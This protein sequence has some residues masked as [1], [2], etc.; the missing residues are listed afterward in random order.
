MNLCSNRQP[1]PTSR[2]AMLQQ[3]GTG[4]GALALNAMLTG[5]GLAASKPAPTTARAK[6]VIF[7]FMHGGPS[8]VDL[9]DPKPLLKRD[10]GK[11]LPFKEPRIVSHK[12]GN[13]LP[14]P[15]QFSRHGQ[16]GAPVSEL[17]PHIGSI[18]DDLCFI[19]SMHCSNSRH[20]GAL[21]ELHTGSDTFT[22]PAM[23][24]WIN[25]G[26]G[27]ENENLPGFITIN[28]SGS[29]GGAGAWSPAFLPARHGGT[30]ISGSGAEMKIPFIES[31]ISK[32]KRQL[33][34]IDLIKAFNRDHLATHGTDSEL[35]SRIASYELAFRM[36][37]EVPGIQDLSNEPAHIKKMYGADEAPTKGFAEQCMMA[38]RFSEAGV[39]FVQI[40]HRYWDSHSNLRKE[41]KKLSAEM[42]K[43]V[44]ALITDL[45]QRG[46]LEDTLVL[47]GS[48]F[49]RTPTA[50]GND[51]RDHNPHGFTMFMA[52]GG[53]RP[54][55]QYGST[56]DY[57]YYAQ[58]QPVHFHDLHATILHL[59]GIDHE[60]LTYRYAGRDFRLTDVHGHVVNGIIA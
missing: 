1:A 57:G 55:I 33:Q 59:L 53:T 49:G 4:F 15:W 45:K 25:Y 31:P 60:Q 58:D 41:H 8:S 11:P 27:S 36:Q 20:G 46:L 16:S 38:R 24:A 5:N 17:L 54:G 47:W 7:V 22:R 13:L 34:E 32:R 37:M 9:F 56:D 43:P 51:G 10:A 35:E 29:H 28:P 6:R 44:A 39:R 48:E 26:L 3:A 21:L 42:D 23:G 18:A 52:G 40:T 50:Q 30:R 14:S 2:R 19:R 12:T